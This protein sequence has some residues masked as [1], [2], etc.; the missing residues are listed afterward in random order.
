MATASISIDLDELAAAVLRALQA[1]DE[2][3][4]VVRRKDIEHVTLSMAD[5]FFDAEA[6]VLNR[7]RGALGLEPAEITV[8]CSDP[9]KAAE[10]VERVRRRMTAAARLS[11]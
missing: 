8:H 9:R 4:V 1:D 6:D 2:P 10:A 3:M 7:L 5:T 11:A